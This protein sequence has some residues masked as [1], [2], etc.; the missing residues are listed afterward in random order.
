M[1]II[2]S[3]LHISLTQDEYNTHTRTQQHKPV[4]SADHK[5]ADVGDANGPAKDVAQLWVRVAVGGGERRHV[6]RIA[7]GLVT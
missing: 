4:P 3:L 7:D 6:D 1:K 2:N 5:V